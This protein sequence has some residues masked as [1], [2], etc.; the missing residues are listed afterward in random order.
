[1][2]SA[3][4]HRHAHVDLPHRVLHRGHPRPQSAHP[5]QDFNDAAVQIEGDVQKSSHPVARPGACLDI[6]AKGP[7]TE[8]A[9]E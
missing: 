3:Y 4:G 1:M 7:D 9:F 2:A 6:L 8:P 5:V